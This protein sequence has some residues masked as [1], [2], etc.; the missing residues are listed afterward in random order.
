MRELSV[1]F[2]PQCGRYAYYQL[3]KHTICPN[4]EV[5]MIWLDMRYQDFM[6]LDL[7]E[8]DSLII[9]R[10][11]DRHTSITGRIISADR[12]HNY[13]A[14]IANLSAHIQELE[15]DNQKLNET[16]DW[17]HQTIWELLNKNKALE[18]QLAECSQN[19]RS[20]DE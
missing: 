3:V 4:C 20:S 16:V 14:A 11:L 7:E 12:K 9:Q 2:C 8:R 10:I 13:R 19:S 18:R 5:K 6:N 17:M 1:Y 15:Q